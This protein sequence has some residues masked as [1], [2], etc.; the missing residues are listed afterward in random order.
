M[1][2]QGHLGM[3]AL[4][5]WA[6]LACCACSEER[7]LGEQC[8]GPFSGNATIA[9]YADGGEPGLGT[10]FGTHC[11]PCD[12]GEP[13]LDADGCPVFVTFAS[14]GGDICIGPRLIALDDEPPS[15]DDGGGDDAGAEPDE[16]D[17]GEDE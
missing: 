10:V 12:E 7:V 9:P 3:R 6:V 15:T 1:L 14:C 8:P 5:L 2:H 11:A 17:G 4:A 13:E 16:A